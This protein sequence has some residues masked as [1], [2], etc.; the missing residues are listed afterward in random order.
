MTDEAAF[1]LAAPIAI[2]HLADLLYKK[3]AVKVVR[4][5]RKAG[6]TVPDL[7]AA[8][9]WAKEKYDDLFEQ[10]VDEH[11]EGWTWKFDRWGAKAYYDQHDNHVFAGDG[12]FTF[13][14]YADSAALIERIKSHNDDHE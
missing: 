11:T 9:D 14:W 8:C 12:S 1:D 4:A 13:P 3:Q 10:I 6:I 2:Y 5:F 7:D